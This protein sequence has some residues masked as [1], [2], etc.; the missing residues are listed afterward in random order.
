MLCFFVIPNFFGI[1]LLLCE[2]T[3]KQV[4]GDDNKFIDINGSAH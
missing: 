3:L 4:Q 2:K 1:S